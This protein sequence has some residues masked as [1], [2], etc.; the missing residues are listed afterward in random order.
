MQVYACTVRVPE[1]CL[2]AQLLAHCCS[3]P[4]LQDTALT[5]ATLIQAMRVTRSTRTHDD[6]TAGAIAAGRCVCVRVWALLAARAL[7][8]CGE[9]RTEGGEQASE[10][11]ARE[12]L[13]DDE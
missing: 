6:A 10:C 1:C 7:L 4:A 5:V 3:L 2:E 11:V 9:C 12:A 8:P 13:A